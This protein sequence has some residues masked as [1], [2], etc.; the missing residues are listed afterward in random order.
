MCW[1]LETGIRGRK[2]LVGE[3]RAWEGKSLQGT[4]QRCWAVRGE[5]ATCGVSIEGLLGSR[6]KGGRRRSLALGRGSV[7]GWDQVLIIIFVSPRPCKDSWTA[8]LQLR[9]SVFYIGYIEMRVS[10]SHLK[11]W[12]LSSPSRPHASKHRCSWVTMKTP[13][14]P[15]YSLPPPDCTAC[16]SQAWPGSHWSLG[17]KDAHR[18]WKRTSGHWKNHREGS[19]AKCEVLS[20]RAHL[21]L[22]SESSVDYSLA[23]L[24]HWARWLSETSG[25]SVL[26]LRTPGISTGTRKGMCDGHQVG[27]L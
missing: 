17:T 21:S 20:G 25:T 6:G 7:V 26:D 8:F 14:L 2:F 3:L 22:Y 24:A 13:P 15:H 10:G 16:P 11:C 18:L 12:M 1:C 5:I 23:C 4:T 27:F 9:I 19:I